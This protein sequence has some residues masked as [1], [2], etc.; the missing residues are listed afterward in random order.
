MFIT[1]RET[2][3]LLQLVK[4]TLPLLFFVCITLQLF[5]QKK[6]VVMYGKVIDSIG[7]IKN[8]NIINLNTNKGTF[9]ND[10]GEFRIKAALGDSLRVSSVQHEIAITIMT[11]S[12]LRTEYLTIKLIKKTYSLEE[13]VIKRHD[14]IGVLSSD[15][16][17]T[18]E[19][20]KAKALKNTMDFSDVDMTA[21]V[22]DDHIDKK[23]RPPQAET[24]PNKA[25]LGAG[26]AIGFAFKYSEKL[27]A[28][29]RKIAY[30]RKFPGLIL[31]EFGEKFFFVD[32][33]IPKN[34]YY[35]FLEY[36]NI[37]GIEDLYLK[38]KKLEVIKILTEE[39]VAYLKIIKENS[40][41]K[42]DEK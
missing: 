31:N 36:C 32:L 5:S 21:P 24:D 9:S 34:K 8:A 22:K 18:P 7:I 2:N 4:K 33:K 6:E 26:A 40:E 39:S 42:P 19:D 17:K 27:W 38:Q 15:R 14:L 28:L 3:Q 37:K 10:A 30:Q 35:H 25:F 16:N 23:V 11:E 20:L 29:R 1:F 12:I 13:I 41:K